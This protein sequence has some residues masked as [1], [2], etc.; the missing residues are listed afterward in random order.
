MK[1][2]VFVFIVLA[3]VA[4]GCG[5]V[6]TESA[7]P[8][9]DTASSA[10]GYPGPF[11]DSSIPRG[12]YPDGMDAVCEITTA[13]NDA[14]DFYG[15][16]GA[17]KL[18]RGTEFVYTMAYDGKVEQ[19]SMIAQAGSIYVNGKL[20]GH[21]D[22]YV[23]DGTNTNFGFNSD[24]MPR[25]DKPHGTVRAFVTLRGQTICEAIFEEQS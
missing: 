1:K 8:A 21:F 13:G 11:D 6:V 2:I 14:R 17:T 4:A 18:D 7:P 10:S 9:I 23:D 20:Y 25:I 22:G 15:V 16:Y 24:N 12:T 19:T 3:F 5:E